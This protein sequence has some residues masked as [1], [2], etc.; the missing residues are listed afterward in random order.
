MSGEVLGPGPHTRVRRLA[1]KAQYE[2][3]VI[4]EIIDEAHVA[5]RVIER[6]VGW[7]LACG[8]G[9]VATAAVCHQRGLTGADAA[10][11]NREATLLSRIRHPGVVR[12]VGEPEANRWMLSLKQSR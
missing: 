5:I 8:T 10:R 1:T 9:S 4:F 7:T 11:F 12:Y 6:G 2:R 3:D